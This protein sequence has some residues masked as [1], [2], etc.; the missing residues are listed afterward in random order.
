[1]FSITLLLFGFRDFTALTLCYRCHVLEEE[2]DN[3]KAESDETR[4]MVE[5]E[6]LKCK[7]LIEQNRNLGEKNEVFFFS[8]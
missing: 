8:L 6:R 2:N 7:D 1:M 5:K 3:L 4:Q